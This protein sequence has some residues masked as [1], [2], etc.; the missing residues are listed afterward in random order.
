M[1]PGNLFCAL[2][3]NV[4]AADDTELVTARISQVRDCDGLP[5]GDTGHSHLLIYFTTKKNIHA[6]RRT[7][8]KI[9]LCSI[10]STYV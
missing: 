10:F 5:V 2:S 9:L 4:R 8:M 3:Q 6:I 7:D 1:W